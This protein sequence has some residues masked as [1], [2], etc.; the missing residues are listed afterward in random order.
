MTKLKTA[1]RKP[2]KASMNP[3][4]VSHSNINNFKSA[5]LSYTVADFVKLGVH[6]S[7][8]AKILMARGVVRSF[9]IR[10][11]LLRFNR[12]LQGRL[13]IGY[14]LL[15]SGMIPKPSDKHTSKFAK[16]YYKHLGKLETLRD[17]SS[18]LTLIGNSSGYRLPDNDPQFVKLL[19]VSG[20]SL[21]NS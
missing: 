8:A 19:R 2:L 13:T 14:K 16:Q 15:E 18:A 4:F 7:A 20:A 21:I 9:L 3:L 10:R 5:K 1:L 6:P 11:A 17:I 12:E